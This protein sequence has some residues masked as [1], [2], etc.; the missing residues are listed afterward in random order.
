[1]A[2]PA[3]VTYGKIVG[4]YLLA[5]ADT[6]DVDLNP[7]AVPASGTVTFTPGPTKLLITPSTPHTTIVPLPVVC[8]FDPTT[9]DLL[10]PNGLAGVWL[11]ATDNPDTVPIDWTYRVR[12]EF[13]GL[14]T[15]VTFDI[16]VPGGVTADLTTLTPVPTSTG[17]YPDRIVLKAPNDST[18]QVAV[19]NTGVLST[20]AL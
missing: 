19:S 7:D 20:V 14:P 9:G 10:G 1:M 3:N 13:D 11:V 6:A 2:L 8:T 18:W 17:T 4:R 16:A 5:V 15:P 12:I